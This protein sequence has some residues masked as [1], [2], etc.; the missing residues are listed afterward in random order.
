MPDKLASNM[1]Q[2]L[3]LMVAVL[4]G[5]PL[6]EEESLGE[7]WDERLLIDGELEAGQSDEDE[8]GTVAPAASAAGTE[9]GR[10]LLREPAE[11]Y[12]RRVHAEFVEARSRLNKPTDGVTYVRFVE[13]LAR[14][15]RQLKAR[16][17]C[18]Y[19]RFEVTVREGQVLL[20]P[21]PIP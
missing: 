5:Q 9:R 8:L 13:K 15:E 17:G 4:R 14:E 6:P 19:V 1:A 20:T 21:I 10:E 12:Y 18:R 2:S 11:A 7:A 3:N 16:L